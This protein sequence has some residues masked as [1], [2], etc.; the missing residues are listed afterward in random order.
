MSQIAWTCPKSSKQFEFRF[1]DKNGLF[2]RSD[3]SPRLVAGTSALMC[4]E[5]GNSL[6]FRQ[7]GRDIHKIFRWCCIMRFTTAVLVCFQAEVFY[8]NCKESYSN[9]TRNSSTWLFCFHK[10]LQGVFW[11]LWRRICF[12]VFNFVTNPL[13][14]CRC[15][16]FAYSHFGGNN[17]T[18][19]PTFFVHAMSSPSSKNVRC[20]SSLLTKSWRQGHH[21]TKTL[22]CPGKQVSEKKSGTLR[23]KWSLGRN[24]ACIRE[25]QQRCRQHK[26]KRHLKINVCAIATILPS[27]HLVRILRFWRTTP[28]LIWCAP[29]WI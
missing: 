1:C 3:L 2:T 5:I 16:A 15:A 29:S 28:Q 24:L 25:L 10:L 27:S 26:G 17:D 7:N 11:L 22:I 6:S 13:L 21:A 12:K 4:E 19:L 18:L 20:L 23:W 9:T 14:P 8:K